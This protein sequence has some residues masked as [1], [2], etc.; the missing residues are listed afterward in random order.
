MAEHGPCARQDR[1]KAGVRLASPAAYGR[2]L[3]TGWGRYAF[4]VEQAA[5][6]G[7]PRRSPQRHENRRNAAGMNGGTA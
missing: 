3:D 6:K 2:W 1:G 5:A 7:E 4:T